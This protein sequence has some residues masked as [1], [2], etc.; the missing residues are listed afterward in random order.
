MTKRAAA[1][2]TAGLAMAGV[3]GGCASTAAVTDAPSVVSA[4]GQR[5]AVH[6]D[7]TPSAMATSSTAAA[8]DVRGSTVGAVILLS[9][10]GGGGRDAF[11]DILTPSATPAAEGV[12]LCV[13]DRPGVGDS[14]P[15]AGEDNSP[16][17]N[18]E[19]IVHAVRAAE[20]PAPYVFV[21]WSY[22]GLV[23][24]LA[25]GEA[26]TSIP[27]ELAGL[28]LVDPVLPEEYRTL[29][30]E[31]WDEGGQQ[32]DMAAGERA[33]A[34]VALGGAPVIVIIAGEHEQNTE[35]WPFVVRRQQEVAASSQDYLVLSSPGAGHDIASDDPV[36]LRAAI[37]A[38]IAA[39]PADIQLPDC[40]AVPDDLAAVTQCLAAD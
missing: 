8:S 40:D 39:A 4:A 23:A 13:V 19:E 32:L 9:G 25:A 20:I 10:L 1:V 15:R 35:N 28:V 24:L 34:D 14:P 16:V 30:T 31:G 37:A 36:A 33:A 38:V 27:A 3:L 11:A 2:A 21:G 18:A 12:P 6:C 29:D 17:T 26:A 5:L 7:S 22:G